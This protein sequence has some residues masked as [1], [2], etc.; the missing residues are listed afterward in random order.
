MIPMT[1]TVEE[2]RTFNCNH[3]D[4]AVSLDGTWQRES[5]T[6]INGI[7]STAS[8]DFVKIIVIEI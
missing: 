1:S 6:S 4:L 2:A 5:P 8:L 3:R 7:V